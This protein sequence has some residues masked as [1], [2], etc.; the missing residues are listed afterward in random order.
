MKFRNSRSEALLQPYHFQ[1][2]TMT[3]QQF[4]FDC[5]INNIVQGM[6]ANVPVREISNRE[7]VSVLT[8][9]M[10]EKALL[11]KASAE[12]AFNE[13][14]SDVRAEFGNNP[15]KMLEFIGNPDNVDRCVELGLMK[16]IEK[17]PLLDSFDKF[18]EAVKQPGVISDKTVET[19]T[20]DTT[21]QGG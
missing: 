14:P 3:Q 5:D 18:T 13:L 7:E 4:A 16:R 1:K 6:S 21:S 12:N 11:T 17:D 20:S 2:D 9:D 10:Y 15:A 19:V 8:P